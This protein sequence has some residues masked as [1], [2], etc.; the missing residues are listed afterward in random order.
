MKSVSRPLKEINGVT[1]KVH[2]CVFLTLFLVK[3]ELGKNYKFITGKFSW[4]V[5]DYWI[6]M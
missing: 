5:L 3:I 6:Q 2:A 1:S 4:L